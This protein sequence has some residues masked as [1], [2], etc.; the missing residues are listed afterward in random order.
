MAT[1]TSDG[2]ARIQI[3]GRKPEEESEFGQNKSQCVFHLLLRRELHYSDKPRRYLM[4]AHLQENCSFSVHFKKKSEVCSLVVLVESISFSAAASDCL[5]KQSQRHDMMHLALV[6]VLGTWT[7]TAGVI[8]IANLCS[9]CEY[10]G[11]KHCRKHARL[12]CPLF[13]PR[14]HRI[15]TC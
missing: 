15:K 6:K 4:N 8:R 13:T 7:I 3:V 14:K 2:L 5:A 10:D 12:S 9:G 11:K 1:F